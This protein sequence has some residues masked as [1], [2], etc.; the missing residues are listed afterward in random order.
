M[1]LREAETEGLGLVIDGFSPIPSDYRPLMGKFRVFRDDY[2][3]TKGGFMRKVT[4]T[5]ALILLAVCIFTQT[6]ARAEYPDKPVNL[7][8]WSG[9]GSGHDLMARMIARLGE[10][11][12]KQPIAVLNK[13]GG[14]GKIA[15]AYGLDK[16]PDGYTLL[17]LSRALTTTLVDPKSD[18]NI[19][20]FTYIS[21]VVVDPYVV[22]VNKTSPFNTLQEL[23]AYAK[24]NPG[25]IRFGGYSV[26]SVDEKIANKIMKETGTQMIYVPFKSGVEPVLGVL[27]MHLDVAVANPSEMLANYEAGKIKVLATCSDKRFAPFEDVPTFKELGF[28]VVEDQWRGIMASK[29]TPPEIVDFWDKTIKKIIAEPEFQKFM[30]SYNMYDGYQPHDVFTA[31]V[32]KQTE[33]NIKH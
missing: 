32:K 14:K 5:L 1:W 16:A 23:I 29:D 2:L 20:R 18:L 25:K 11:L 31:L 21:R 8:C 24:E 3:L 33:E 15:L 30:K 10:E 26:Q 7:V 17:T 27:G 28:D 12:I 6:D 13:T 9:A 19:D 22:L 4:S